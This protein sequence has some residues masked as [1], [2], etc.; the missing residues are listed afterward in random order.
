MTTLLHRFDHHS[1][2]E[3]RMQ[4]A[5]FHYLESSRAARTA[6]AENYIGLPLV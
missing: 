3:Q 2:F 5:E 1:P 4:D 6:L